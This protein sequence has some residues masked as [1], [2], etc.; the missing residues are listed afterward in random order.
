MTSKA[1]EAVATSLEITQ[2]GVIVAGPPGEEGAA[3]VDTDDTD[4]SNASGDQE[5]RSR[6]V[7]AGATTENVP[8]EFGGDGRPSALEG[9]GSARTQGEGEMPVQVLQVPE[10]DVR[11]AEGLGIQVRT[12]RGENKGD[13]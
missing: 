4:I 10:I 8:G 1:N 5:T 2:I 9:G 7:P 3:P 13:R 6:S 12:R 11:A